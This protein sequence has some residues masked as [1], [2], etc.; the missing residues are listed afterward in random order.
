MRAL[1]FDRYGPP[2]VVRVS[3]V[4]EPDVGAHDILVRVHASA[5][6]T[7]DWRIRA[8]AFPGLLAVPAR[9]M[10]GI[11]SPRKKRLGS[12]FAG[13]VAAVGHAVTGYQQGD[14]VFG[15]TVGGGASAAFA[16]IRQNAAVAKMPAGISFPQAAAL[17]FGAGTALAFLRDFAKLQPGQRLL[18]VGGSGGVGC[19]AVQIG[20]ALGA[21]VTAVAGPQNQ[22]F[23]Y[24]LGA[25]VALDYTQSGP[26]GWGTAY[27]VIIDAIGALS[28]RKARAMLRAGG[29]FFPLI[30]GAAELRAA[31]GNLWH[32]R[33]VR[34]ASNTDTAARLNDLTAMIAAGRLKPVID[35]EFDLSEAAEAHL[36]VES[37]HRRGA[38]ILLIA[39]SAE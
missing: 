35:S 5:V 29:Q 17:P 39:D 38:V 23:L 11:F 18:V 10:F 19:Y 16:A 4:P 33:K 24:D 9:L 21:E 37:R 32:D 26:E 12:E 1:T 3:D 30:F 8:G 31:F 25:D 15:I 34:I 28:P 20:K 2:D 7:G 36:K 6:N 27:D 22:R 13:T 14:R